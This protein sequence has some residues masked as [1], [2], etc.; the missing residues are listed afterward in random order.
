MDKKEFRLT[1]LYFYISGGCNL[2]CKHC[3]ISPESKNGD[4]NSDGV[5]DVI[6]QAVELGA[7]NVKLTGG[8]PFLRKDIFQ[9][10]Q[11][12]REKNLAVIIETN[13]TFIQE[14][15]AEELK[16]LGVGFISVS[17]DG[18]DAEFHDKLRGVKGAF[19]MAVR[20][21]KALKK[22]GFSPQV[23]ACI[24][25][26]N[27]SDIERL[28]LLVQDLGAGS[29]KLNPIMQIGR[30]ENFDKE[31]EL[32]GVK[33]LLELE[34]YIQENLQPK[35]K[36][37]ILLDI[38]FAFK[39]LSYIKSNHSRCGLLGMIGILSDGTVSICGIGE[40]IK[41]LNMGSIK[42]NR[43][44]DI[45]EDNEILNFIRVNIPDKLEGIC[46][47]CV[48]KRLCLGKCRAHAYHES[49]SLTAPFYFCQEAYE[50]SFFPETRII[51]SNISGP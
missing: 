11:F 5:K 13:G 1:T 18:P 44:R 2:S 9:I 25:R 26:K 22:A 7:R 40:E 42:K 35:V 24:Y 4:L 17:I 3:W 50:S 31:K 20:G 33:E 15:E 29:L 27:V 19:E 37:S 43:L 48:F 39:K 30:G 45:W 46:E 49:K 23:I 32:L 51:N 36:L 8:E 41:E 28:A 16:R 38:P 14:R 21:I 12:I 6:N 47:R 34:R 10:L